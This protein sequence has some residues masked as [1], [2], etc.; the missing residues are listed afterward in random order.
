MHIAVIANASGLVVV[1][2]TNMAV[3]LAAVDGLFTA[4][5]LLNIFLAKSSKHS[6]MVRKAVSG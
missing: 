1:V 6:L 3:L 4:L 2:G 5:A